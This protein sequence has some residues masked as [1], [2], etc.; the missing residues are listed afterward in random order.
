MNRKC[1]KSR[2]THN[3][4]LLMVR[5]NMKEKFRS[6]KRKSKKFLK[7][8]L[9]LNGKSKPEIFKEMVRLKQSQR[10]AR[11]LKINGLL[12]TSARKMLKDKSFCSIEK[13]IL[14]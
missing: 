12:R 5:K 7:L 4:G 3:F 10:N 14:S 11:C 6:N 9:Y 8:W 1:L 2:Y 13:E